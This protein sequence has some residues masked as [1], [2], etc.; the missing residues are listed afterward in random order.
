[1]NINTIKAALADEI[2]GFCPDN[3]DFSEKLFRKMI[4][5]SVNR[6]LPKDCLY[7]ELG[8]LIQAYSKYQRKPNEDTMLHL[9]EEIGDA[10]WALGCIVN[11]CGLDESIIKNILR[12]KAIKSLRE[13][14]GRPLNIPE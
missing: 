1:M 10:F 8:E 12:F 4:C 14:E 2:D 6:P 11:T 9:C 5:E 7:E 13:D 3:V